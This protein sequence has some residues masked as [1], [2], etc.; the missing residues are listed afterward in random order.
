MKN[1][2]FVLRAGVLGLLIVFAVKTAVF[3]GQSTGSENFSSW[4]CA[5]VY[6]DLFHKLGDRAG[7]RKFTRREFVPSDLKDAGALAEKL[8]E[9]KTPLTRFIAAQL[10][11]KTKQ[12]LS[13]IGKGG[14]VS[15]EFNAALLED[16]NKL[17]DGKNLYKKEYFDGVELTVDTQYLLVLRKKA[18]L[19]D[20][21]DLEGEEIKEDGSTRYA[22][23]VD[24]NRKLLEDAFAAEISAVPSGATEWENAAPHIKLYYYVVPLA[25]YSFILGLFVGGAVMGVRLWLERRRLKGGAEAKNSVAGDG[26][27]GVEVAAAT[28][29]PARGLA[30]YWPV[31][32]AITGFFQLGHLLGVAAFV[33]VDKTRSKWWVKTLSRGLAAAAVL[34]WGVG[35]EL[36]WSAGWS[37]LY[38]AVN[39]YLK[40]FFHLFGISF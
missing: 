12:L 3:M 14:A 25:F 34:F 7:I 39:H 2:W 6:N 11:E 30:A 13:G 26:A 35:T 29:A 23:D 33:L 15:D 17:I 27:V 5:K 18:P 24:I 20:F 9:P 37:K 31:L 32:L 21:S 19:A 38:P 10:S 4:F 28:S 16:L 22:N 1:V 36:Y 8:R 40:G